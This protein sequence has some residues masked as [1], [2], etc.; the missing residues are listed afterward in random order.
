VRPS[1][2]Q[3]VRR[4]LAGRIRSDLEAAG[5]V[6]E[7]ES[8]LLRNPTDAHATLVFDPR[9]RGRSDQVVLKFRKPKV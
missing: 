3:R 8:A 4:H 6:F 7:G 2:T 5:F 1:L 9:I